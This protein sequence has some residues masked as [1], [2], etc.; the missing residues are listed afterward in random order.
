MEPWPSSFIYLVIYYKIQSSFNIFVNI[1]FR[2][3]GLNS[4]DP[5]QDLSTD[6][7]IDEGGSMVVW[8]AFDTKVSTFSERIVGK[9]ESSWRVIHT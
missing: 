4:N 7:H 9:L 6:N 3:L 8:R 2:I 1:V 5:G